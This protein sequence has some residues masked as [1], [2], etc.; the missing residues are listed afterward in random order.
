METIDDHISLQDLRK[1]YRRLKVTIFAK[2]EPSFLQKTGLWA[3]EY[4]FS[5][6]VKGILKD[7]TEWAVLWSDLSSL[8]KSVEIV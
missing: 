6:K 4:P 7:E 3:R 1:C 8:Y 2:E 5:V